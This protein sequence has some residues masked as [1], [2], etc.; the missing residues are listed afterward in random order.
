MDTSKLLSL[1]EASSYLGIHPNSL[2]KRCSERWVGL[3]PRFFRVF[4]RLKFRKEDLDSYISFFE[5][6]APFSNGAEKQPPNGVPV[7]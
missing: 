4:G 6:A 7:Q 1:T 5:N 3:K 2:R